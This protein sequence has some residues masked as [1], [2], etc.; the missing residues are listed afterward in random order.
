MLFSFTH[1][2]TRDLFQIFAFFCFLI[3]SPRLVSWHG[4]FVERGGEGAKLDQCQW[5]SGDSVCFFRAG[6]C[7]GKVL[8]FGGLVGW[9]IAGV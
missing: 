8:D 7:G 2:H 3:F 6:F 5:R 9:F 1:S 4:F